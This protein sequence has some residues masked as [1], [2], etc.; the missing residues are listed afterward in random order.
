M[1]GIH[2]RREFEQ[3]ALMRSQRVRVR[4]PARETSGVLGALEQPFRHVLQ[5]AARHEFAQPLDV[6]ALER[7]VQ[8]LAR[9]VGA[10]HRGFAVGER[11]AHGPRA[12]AQREVAQEVAAEP[13]D[14]ADPCRIDLGGEVAAPGRA[15]RGPELPLEIGRGLVG[16]R[17]RGDLLERQRRREPGDRSTFRVH[18][19]AELMTERLHDRRRLAG[20]GAGVDEQV[21]GR[22]DDTALGGPERLR[23]QTSTGPPGMRQMSRAGQ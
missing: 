23:H 8:R 6:V 4:R 5:A 14:G 11:A 15:K 9:T 21:S 12:G 13:V 17:D 18:F 7:G 19:D 16:E 10:E 22:L 2:P 20:A 1:R 3:G